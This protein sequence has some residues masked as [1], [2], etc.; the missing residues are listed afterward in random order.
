MELAKRASYDQ[1]GDY[2][3]SQDLCVGVFDGT[4]FNSGTCDP[5]KLKSTDSRFPTSSMIIRYNQAPNNVTYL[6]SVLQN[7][8]KETQAQCVMTSVNT[9]ACWLWN[10]SLDKC[11]N[12]YYYQLTSFKKSD[13]MCGRTEPVEAG[14]AVYVR[15]SDFQEQPGAAALSGRAITV[16]SVAVVALA[17]FALTF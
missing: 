10:S 8:T 12:R 13:G 6:A 14:Y 17:L 9:T 2:L 7:L 1:V 15:R 5:Q 3:Y 11:L 4:D 16:K